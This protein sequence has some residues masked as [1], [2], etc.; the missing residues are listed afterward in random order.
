MDDVD[1]ETE[2]VG[3]GVVARELALQL[4]R[5]GSAK[6]GPGGVEVHLGDG[7]SRAR[8][9]EVY[10]GPVAALEAYA[11]GD[12]LLHA[13]C[14]SIDQCALA[15]LGGQG[16][17]KSTLSCA[18]VRAGSTFISDGSLVVN[19][20]TGIVAVGP[21]RWKLTEQSLMHLG[22]DA[23]SC[24]YVNE[25]RVKRYVDLPTPTVAHTPK[26][27]LVLLVTDGSDERI[28]PL[29]PHEQAIA[30]LTH[31]Y[32]VNL[33]PPS[34]HGTL[35]ERAAGLLASGAS[36]K[37]LVRRKNWNALPATVDLVLREL[38]ACVLANTSGRP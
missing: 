37:R 16:A 23:G 9:R 8:A 26:L 13:S 30:L 15:I 24:A 12:V 3:E 33:F 35:L 7:L 27:G 36:V 19:P 10:E 21:P 28:E 4:G 25:E 14:V 1:V 6:V 11:G 34:E 22:L 20:H 17:G 32:L 31:T 38:R 18:C 5:Y 29:A 2:F